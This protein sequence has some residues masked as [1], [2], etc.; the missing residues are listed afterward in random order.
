MNRLVRELPLFQVVLALL[1]AVLAYGTVRRLTSHAAEAAE[2]RHG[3]SAALAPEQPQPVLHA[4]DGNADLGPGSDE[5][6]L[7]RHPGP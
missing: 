1:V 6:A 7:A 2:R 5:A 3:S 4:A